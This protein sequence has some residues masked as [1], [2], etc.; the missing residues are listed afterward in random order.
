MSKKLVILVAAAVVVLP[1]VGLGLLVASI[2]FLFS[3][4]LGSIFGFGFGGPSPASAASVPTPPAVIVAL[5]KAVSTAPPSLAPCQVPLPLLLAQQDVESGFNPTAVSPAGALGLA[6][7]E[8]T[9][10]AHYAEPVPPGGATPPAPFDPVDAA[11][12]EAR[13]LC[14][15]G[16]STNP[17][18]ALIVYN[19]G[20]TSPACVAA[21]SGYASKIE[22]LAAVYAAKLS[23]PTRP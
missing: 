9:T 12:A 15:N 23:P 7:F 8:P 21:S 17:T 19:C 11:Y 10:F 1:V 14:A 13:M 20:N 5:D 2:G 3:G 22:G 16:V 4:F 18:A 6:Q